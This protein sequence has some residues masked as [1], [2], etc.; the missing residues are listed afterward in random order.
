M[1][2]EKL[3]D[4]SFAAPASWPNIR[5]TRKYVTETVNS[6]KLSKKDKL[7]GL[8][9]LGAFLMKAKTAVAMNRKLR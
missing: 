8:D 2:D 9:Y 6:G 1:P 4:V 7:A 3:E 5:S